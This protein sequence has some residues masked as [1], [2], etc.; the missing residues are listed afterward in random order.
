EAVT[1]AGRMELTEN[2][3]VTYFRR[4]TITVDGD[5]SDWA[6]IGAMPVTLAGSAKTDSVEKYWLPFIAYAEGSA[7][8]VR[9]AGAWDEDHFYVCAEVRDA[10]AQYRPSM[11]DGIYYTLHD[12]PLDY[13][14]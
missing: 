10:H 6:D 14:Y 4:G 5:L 9:F 12:A 7:A 3:H 13:L 11:R 2:L 1:P 8:P